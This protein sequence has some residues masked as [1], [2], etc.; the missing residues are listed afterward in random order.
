MV[1]KVTA[2]TIAQI[3]AQAGQH[4][5]SPPSTQSLLDGIRRKLTTQDI[6][7]SP[8]PSA[9]EKRKQEQK[10]AFDLLL[11]TVP[12]GFK[13]APVL[14]TRIPQEQNARVQGEYTFGVR[15]RFFQ[16]LA[17]EHAPDLKSLGI[18]EH[19]IAKMLRG[20]DPSTIDGR[21]YDISVDHIIERSGSGRLGA[22]KDKD[23]LQQDH[24]QPKYGVNHFGNLI[25]LPEK[26]HKFKNALNTMQEIADIKPGESRW[27][28]MLVPDATT[29]FVSPPQRPGHAL[30]GIDLLAPNG[31]RH[32][33]QTSYMAAQV[34]EEINAFGQQK[35]MRRVLTRMEKTAAQRGLD[36][37]SLAHAQG[38]RK[39]RGRLSLRSTF[40]AAIRDDQELQHDI[41]MLIRPGLAEVRDSLVM[42]FNHLAEDAKKRTGAANGNLDAFAKVLAGKNMT[43][44]L[45][46]AASYPFPESH[47][48]LITHAQVQKDV[49][50][51]RNAPHRKAA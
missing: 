44:L 32:I 19:G 45:K 25:F 14:Y 50:A 5:D 22:H 46:K 31:A 37:A 42:T 30:H 36:V 10:N 13:L 11:E 8:D 3:S 2:S 27:M 40:N 41:Q 18:C 1:Q 24:I 16:F 23:P 47:D 15:A 17:R 38:S 35:N 4:P 7:L 26:V 20:T 33:G 6:H 34:T 12:D 28:L 43:D 21:Y 29:G 9:R 39:K 49:T 48:L 51:L